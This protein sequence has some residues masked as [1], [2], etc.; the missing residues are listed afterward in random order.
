MRR[1]LHHTAAVCLL[2]CG[3]LTSGIARADVVVVVA[4]DSPVETLSVAALTDIYL[5]RLNRFPDGTAA[6]P[7]DQS[8]RSPQHAAFYRDF[9]GRTPAEIKS[10]WSRLIFTGRGR[11]PQSVRDGNAVAELVAAHRGAIGYL[12]AALVDDSLKVVRI[13]GAAD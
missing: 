13:E 1:T 11:P 6:V 2:A 10:H 7:V 9:L 5:G 4:A 12:D 8:E 3:L